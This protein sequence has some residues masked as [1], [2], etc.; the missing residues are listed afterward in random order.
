MSLLQAEL[1]PLEVDINR[2]A[3]III[4]M[5]NAFVSK[6]GWFDML[7]M[8][9]SGCQKIIAPI[10]RINN[11][12]R[13]KGVKVVYIAHV[14]SPNMPEVGP[15]SP[16]WFKG[17]PP[18]HLEHP[19]WGDK[20]LIRST[21]GTKIVDDL[22]PQEG[23]LLVEKAQYGVF[24]S[25]N[26]DVILKSYDI[27]YL[28]FVGVATNICVQSSLI[29]AFHLDYFCVLVSDATA[30]PNPSFVQETVEMNVKQCF[31]WVTNSENII[32]ILQ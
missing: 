9:I 1:Q 5:E 26:L 19:D 12:A 21:W 8:D 18:S 28:A 3:V 23:D 11:A 31:G 14:Y 4:D 13:A 24:A 10:R 6:G 2:M 32:K 25:S 15:K 30:T 16:Q 17:A 27:K 22:E 7:G 20:M 29:Q